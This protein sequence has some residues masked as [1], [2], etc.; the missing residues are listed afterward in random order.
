MKYLDNSARSLW[1][2]QLCLS[3]SYFC[4]LLS[5]EEDMIVISKIPPLASALQCLLYA[6]DDHLE[7]FE[8]ELEIS[9]LQLCWKPN[10]NFSA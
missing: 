6:G 5:E 2:M 4:K 10:S 1:E 9:N 3:N 8:P 7:G